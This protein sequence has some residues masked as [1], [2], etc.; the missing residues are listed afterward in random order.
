M[1]TTW[2]FILILFL[3]V[4]AGYGFIFRK[5][6]IVVLFVSSYI[7]FV[8][9]NELGS[10]AL[11]SANQIF[12]LESYSPYVP[13]IFKFAL[14]FIFMALLAI[15]AEYLAASPGKKGIVNLILSG[16]YGLLLVAML[17]SIATFFWSSDEE[18]QILSTAP[19]FN[20]IIQYRIWWFLTPA[21]L[22]LLSGFMI[23]RK[24]KKMQG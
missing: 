17:L 18:A 21:I 4:G 14:F 23:A 11:Q 7:S 2:D 8:V 9:I 24:E 20:Y 12:K 6:Q 15:W 19:L 22:M 5:G 10:R 16:I 1:F 13:F 3:C